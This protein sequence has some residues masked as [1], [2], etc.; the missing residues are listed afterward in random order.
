MKAGGTWLA[1]TVA[2]GLLASA[3]LAACRQ[4]SDE[5]SRPAT[6]SL[7][8]EPFG[9]TQK[10][11]PI[12]RYTMTSRSGVRVSFINYGGIITDVSTPDRQGH[13]A[14]VTLGFATLRE[15]ETISPRN[16]L[17][18]GALLGR[19]TN[20]IK[21]G[22]F[23][24]DGHPYQITLTDPPNTIHG[25]A[26]GFDKQIWTV[27][28]LVRSGATVSARLRY[29]SPDGEEGFPGTV[30]AS[31]T[32]SLSQD[33]AFTIRYQATTDQATIVNLSS[34]MSFNLA[35]A[36]SPHGVLGQ[37]LTIDADSYV[38]LD[39]QQ[40]PLGTIAAVAGT[41][42]DFRR[43]TTIG[44]R[45]HDTHPQM[46]MADGYDQYWLF[47]KRLGRVGP[48]PAVHVVDPG[49]GRTME[50]STTQPGTQIYTSGFFGGKTIGIGGRYVKYA[51]FTM[52]TQGYPEAINHPAFPSSVLRPGQRYDTTTV[53]R[54]G[55][56]R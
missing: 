28:P 7:S 21:N 54:F 10:G 20:W 47:N 2:I 31:V 6:A 1:S 4:R 17:Y 44:A 48:Q 38:P 52:E 19:D 5:A 43:P 36:G 39:R 16:E 11:R 51:A 33:G 53:F 37:A 23:T 42:F 50:V 41:P 34:H 9:T 12:T 14:P 30:K 8:S 22:R 56:A 25:G 26:R 49:S 18:F 29:T 3:A 40:I 46:A 45:I 24:L 55:V 27:E 32:Y 35:G 13:L 15:Y